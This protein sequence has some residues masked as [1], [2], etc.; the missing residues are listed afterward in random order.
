MKTRYI[1]IGLG[2]PIA[3]A[4]T[5]YACAPCFNPLRRSD[6]SLAKWLLDLTPVGSTKEEV[7][8]FG[9]GNGWTVGARTPIAVGSPAVREAHGRKIGSYYN[10][11]WKVEVWAFW[12][13]DE[14]GRL[15]DIRIWK[16]AV[17]LL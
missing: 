10:L 11:A 17:P 6:A 8:A 4:A 1:A 16:V 14:H 9:A 13:F 2:V 7:E 5:V 15:T 3:L 12:H